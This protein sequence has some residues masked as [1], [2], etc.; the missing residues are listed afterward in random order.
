MNIKVSP[1]IIGLVAQTFSVVVE[2][3]AHP[4]LLIWLSPKIL[5]YKIPHPVK[6]NTTK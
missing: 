3:V 5:G 2:A 6:I 1:F 4:A